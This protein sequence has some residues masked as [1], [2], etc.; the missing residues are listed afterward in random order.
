MNSLILVLAAQ[1]GLQDPAGITASTYV[2]HVGTGSSTTADYA[3]NPSI[4]WLTPDHGVLCFTKGDDH[5]S[6]HKTWL[7]ETLDGGVTW[8]APEFFYDAGTSASDVEHGD[9][10]CVLSRVADEV[11]HTININLAGP[12]PGGAWPTGFKG[13]FREVRMRR[14]VL[15][16]PGL[17][18]ENWS[19]MEVPIVGGGWFTSEG[20]PRILVHSG[21]CELPTY[22]KER[23]DQC[24]QADLASAPL[25][26][27][28]R[29]GHAWDIEIL[30]RDC[31]DNNHNNGREYEEPVLASGP[32]IP[33]VTFAFIRN[34][35]DWDQ[36][37]MTRV[38][39]KRCY[40]ARRLD[41]ER[42]DSQP[43]SGPVAVP[44]PWVLSNGP[45]VGRAPA[46]LNFDANLQY[47]PTPLWPC[48]S[49]PECVVTV[50][51][52]I[53]CTFRDPTLGDRNVMRVSW[54]AGASW[55][56]AKEL[57]TPQGGMA[58]YA[59]MTERV[60]GVVGIA[61]AYELA[62]NAPGVPSDTRTRLHYSIVSLSHFPK[63]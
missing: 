26:E 2:F 62:V 6:G 5:S 16:D 57:Q 46:E 63:P 31:A 59:S 55:S 3:M 36:V 40:L 53:A 49:K 61:Y 58:L 39:D 33:G 10:G 32:A 21:R 50:Q 29:C 18:S 44:S 51:G 56:E 27:L 19:E 41:G 12:L 30:A 1:L 42:W 52:A 24:Y 17:F 20:H 47:Q 11:I 9:R 38:V 7:Q 25:D 35:W 13:P 48:W 28:G 22:I 43:S 23:G 45:T 60:P 4:L 15:T 34:D 37:S 8:S 54:D 14:R